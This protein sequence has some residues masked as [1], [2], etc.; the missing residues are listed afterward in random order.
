V[1][2][3]DGLIFFIA[4]VILSRKKFVMIEFV[5]YMIICWD[6]IVTSRRRNKERF[7]YT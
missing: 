6:Q 4:I 1:R 5:D 3:K 7:I 2:K